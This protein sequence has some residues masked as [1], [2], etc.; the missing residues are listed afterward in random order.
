M[1]RSNIK[2]VPVANKQYAEPLEIES[3]DY[4]D[5]YKRDIGS[6]T[7]QFHATQL[8]SAHQRASITAGKYYKEEEK[9]DDTAYTTASAAEHFRP[10]TFQFYPVTPANGAR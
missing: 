2:P 8:T 1:F 4:L 3:F 5:R 10:N 7:A 9:T 6:I